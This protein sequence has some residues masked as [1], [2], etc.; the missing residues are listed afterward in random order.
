MKNC[1]RTIRNISIVAFGLALSPAAFAGYGAIAFSP[2]TYTVGEG[3]GYW[4]LADAEQAA[5]NACGQADCKIMNW[6]QNRCNA[7]ATDQSS[8][9]WGRATGVSDAATAVN[10]AI[11]ACGTA[12]CVSRVWICG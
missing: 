11:E 6:E 2:S 5:I 4:D 1:W 8:G 10:A 3:H 9:H 7:F 12:N